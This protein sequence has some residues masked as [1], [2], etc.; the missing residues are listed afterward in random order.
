MV[1]WFSDRID[2][3]RGL[4]TGLAVP[5]VLLGVLDDVASFLARRIA[6]GVFVAAAFTLTTTYLSWDLSVSA[7]GGAMAPSI[8]G[9]VDSNLFDALMAVLATDGFGLRL[10]LRGARPREAGAAIR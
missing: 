1:A 5:T 7:A 6:Q 10:R 9:T 3:E 2:R 8:A 4:W